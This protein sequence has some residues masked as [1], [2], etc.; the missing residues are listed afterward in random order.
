MGGGPPGFG[1]GFTC[2][3]LLGN[4][5]GRSCISPTGLSPPVAG[6]SRPFGY[7]ETMP[8]GAPATPRGKPRGLAS[9]GFARHYSRNLVLISLPRGTEMFHFPRYRPM[10]LCVQRMVV[11]RTPTGFPHSEIPGSMP[12]RGSPGL[13]AASH[14]LHRLLVPRHPSCARIR[15]TGSGTIGPGRLGCNFIPRTMLLSKNYAR[16]PPQEGQRRR[17]APRRIGGKLPRPRML[18]SGGRAWNRTRDLVLIRD[19][20]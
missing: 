4:S 7:A 1:R 15:L 9:S 2:P 13:I 10:R 19:A 11:G 6:L 8:C 16:L 12:A 3:V 17:S 5:P 20:L 18:A 14:V